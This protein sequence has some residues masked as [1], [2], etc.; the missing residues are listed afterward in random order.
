M[1]YTL[2]GKAPAGSSYS[3]AQL[4]LP[5]PLCPSAYLRMCE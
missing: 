1:E 5:L 4:A 3:N 2:L